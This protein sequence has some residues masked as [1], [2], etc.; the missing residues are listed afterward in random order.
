[1]NYGVLSLVK[2]LV[3][4]KLSCPD[5]FNSRLNTAGAGAVFTQVGTLVAA[6]WAKNS[7]E[8][9]FGFGFFLIGLTLV[10]LGISGTILSCLEGCLTAKKVDWVKRLKTL[11]NSVW[12]IASGFVLF[13]VGSVVSYNWAKGSMINLTGYGLFLLGIPV[14]FFGTI[15]FSAVIIGDFRNNR[16]SRTGPFVKSAVQPLLTKCLN[17]GFESPDEVFYC[18][19]CG[20]SL[21]FSK[22]TPPRTGTTQCFRCGKISSVT[23]SFCGRCGASL[24]ENDDTKIY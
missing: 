13:V 3:A 8:N 14:I 22:S 11:E 5:S 15:A 1:V 23:S 9:Y 4:S 6:N 7:L 2:I 12:A 20:Y 18:G 16:R 10:V 24:K 17:C 19:K 21:A